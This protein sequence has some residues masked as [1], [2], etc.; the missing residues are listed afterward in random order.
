MGNGEL[1]VSR[2]IG[3][4]DYKGEGMSKYMWGFPKGHPKQF[5]ADLVISA[6]SILEVDF[7]AQDK[8]LVLA[9][10]GIWDVLDSQDV[11]DIVSESFEKGLSA[12]ESSA[13]LGRIA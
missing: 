13:R 2:A 11:V 9:C 8:F 10:D 3:D 5:K 7:T 4:P 6:P 1:A 12:Q